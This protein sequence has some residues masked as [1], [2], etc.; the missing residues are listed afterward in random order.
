MALHTSSQAMQ[1][2]EDV[3]RRLEAR[4]GPLSTTPPVRG[5]RRGVDGSRSDA[6]GVEAELGACRADDPKPRAPRITCP[7]RGGRGTPQPCRFPSPPPGSWSSAGPA[8][9]A[10]T[11]CW[12]NCRNASQD[13]TSSSLPPRGACVRACSS[14]QGAGAGPCGR[15]AA[16][17]AAVAT[18]LLA[19]WAG[20]AAALHGA[21]GKRV[22]RRPHQVCAPPRVP[23]AAT[24]PSP[25]VRHLQGPTRWGSGWSGLPLCLQ[26]DIRD[27]DQRGPAGGA[28]AGVRGLQGHPS[29][30]GALGTHGRL[31]PPRRPMS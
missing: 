25:S 19:A 12:P 26:G 31:H 15:A 7:G 29:S 5:S 21:P 22:E 3:L 20:P 8:A 24:L 2:A 10:K 28:C 23:G 1:S 9:L 27:L 11:L 30:S 13:C 6:Y 18:P 4:I 16:G 17:H 14:Q